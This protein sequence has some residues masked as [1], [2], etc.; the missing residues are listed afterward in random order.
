MT[1]DHRLPNSEESV[2]LVEQGM[3]DDTIL[4]LDDDEL[5]AELAAYRR[6]RPT[7]PTDTHIDATRGRAP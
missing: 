4:Y 6:T 2:E 3:L 7:L 1:A 5:K